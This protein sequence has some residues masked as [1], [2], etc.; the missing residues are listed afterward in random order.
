MAPGYEIALCLEGLG[1]AGLALGLWR[2][3]VE[4]AARVR[5]LRKVLRTGSDPR[6][7]PSARP[8]RDRTRMVPHL[9]GRGDTR[10]GTSAAAH[11]L[12]RAFLRGA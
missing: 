8:R 10:T 9:T 2:L 11:A 12:A 7:V 6:L 3:R 4:E 1:L 5:A